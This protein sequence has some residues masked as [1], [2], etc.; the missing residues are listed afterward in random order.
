MIDAS[1]EP[2]SDDED[3]ELVEEEVHEVDAAAND[4]VDDSIQGFFEHKEPVY[5]VSTHPN[6]E[7]ILSG[8]GDDKS[9]LWNIN[10]GEKFHQITAHTDSVVASGFSSDG[11]YGATGGMDGSIKVFKVDTKSEILSLDG[12]N[13][14]IWIDWHPR[15][16]VLLASGRDGSLW[17][18]QIPSGNCMN[19][20]S[21]HTD[22]ITCG[23]FTPD[24]K[25][26][27]SGS[28]DG[29][30]IIW[31]PRTAAAL[32][33]F[34]A[35]DRRFVTS[36]ITSLAVSLDSTLCL[37]G[38]AE[39]QARLIHVGNGKILEAFDGHS[40]SIESIAFCKSLPLVA[41]SSVDGSICLWDLT[42]MRIRH[43][44]RHDDAVTKVVWH[45]T[46]PLLFSSSLDKTVK[47]WDA[48]TGECLKVWKGHQDAV[49]DI[50]VSADG[51][52]VVSGSDDGT[53]LVFSV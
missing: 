31:D 52:K 12:P 5:T 7:I 44:C 32:F 43:T 4:F 49:L 9:Y 51:Q 1:G 40:E 2:M 35:D 10:S 33:K 16:P 45:P 36:S 38:S 24:G 19:V 41:T 27:I 13:E 53:L 15:G 25:S 11:Q 34:N 39:G 30:L 46:Q 42:T 21:G 6:N 28:E 8:G 22:S 47:L 3:N 18:W 20:F 17:M 29:T 37:V 26:I 50:A 23:G 48:R 14:V